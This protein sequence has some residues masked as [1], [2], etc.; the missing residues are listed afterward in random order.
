[1]APKPR[2]DSGP[3]ILSCP[4]CP[5]PKCKRSRRGCGA[6]SSVESMTGHGCLTSGFIGLFPYQR[7]P[8]LP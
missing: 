6:R 1:M 8:C 3:W 4:Q 2:L 5:N 7:T